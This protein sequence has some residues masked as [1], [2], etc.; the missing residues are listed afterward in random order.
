MTPASAAARRSPAA[1]G[2]VGLAAFPP[3]GR[4]LG[5]RPLPA[6]PFRPARRAFRA[7]RLGA[8]PQIPLALVLRA[9]ACC[10]SGAAASRAPAPSAPALRR[11]RPHVIL[12]P[13]RRQRA[14]K[15]SFGAIHARCRWLLSCLFALPEIPLTRSGSVL[16]RPSVKPSS[17]SLRRPRHRPSSSAIAA[18]PSRECP[19]TRPP[20]FT[21]TPRRA[22]KSRLRRAI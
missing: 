10:V 16:S 2:D 21:R 12:L 7:G 8:S 18:S 11:P 19:H 3:P 15:S 6:S 4:C 13:R 20:P 14:D 17:G 1:G 22:Q 9:P 5:G